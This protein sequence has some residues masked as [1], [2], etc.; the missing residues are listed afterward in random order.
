MI[1]ESQETSQPK[2]LLSRWPIYVPLVPLFFVLSFFTSNIHQFEFSVVLRPSMAVVTGTMILWG[3]LFLALRNVHKSALVTGVA[4]AV[5]MSLGHILRIIPHFAF[6]LGG[7]NVGPRLLLTTVSIV[8]LIALAVAAARSKRNWAIPTTLANLLTI[9]LILVACYRIVAYQFGDTASGQFADQQRLDQD[10]SDAASSDLPNIYH[11]VLDGYA[12]SDV[13]ARWYGYDNQPFLDQLKARGFFIADKANANYCQTGLSL[14]A[15]LNLDYHRNLPQKGQDRTGLLRDFYKN[16]LCRKLTKRGYEIIS[17]P[18]GYHMTAQ[19]EGATYINDELLNEFERG[20]LETTAMA[21][22]ERAFRYHRQRVRYTLDH[23]ADVADSDKPIFV[24]AHTISPHPPFVFDQAGNDRIVDT[25]YEMADGSDWYELNKLPE[26]EYR[27]QYLGQ[28]KF[29]NSKLIGVIDDILA[30]A[31]R[32]TIIILQSD[33][34]PGSMLSWS[35]IERT[36]VV[37]RMGILSAFYFPDGDYHLLHERISQ[38]NTFRVLFN[39]YFSDD[40]PLLEDRNYFSTWDE[41]Y[42][43]HDVT[44]RINEWADQT[45]KPAE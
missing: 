23:L 45:D 18:S 21:S 22:D 38:V 5:F 33:H 44:E 14:P 36:N 12:R 3:L 17:Y 13:L 37:E 24:F 42:K 32:P 15:T 27:N 10:N 6:R 29:L 34:G 25:P 39:Q 40:L 4:T 8:M 35:T 41:P 26:H 19:I 11:I 43:L 16:A 20:L 1:Q 28:L 9:C 7:L 31:T 2:T 30:R